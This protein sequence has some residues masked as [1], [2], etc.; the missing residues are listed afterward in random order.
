MLRFIWSFLDY[1]E[2]IYTINRTYLLNYR[3]QSWGFGV[4]GVVGVAGDGGVVCCDGAC[5][6]LNGFGSL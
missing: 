2:K 6:L 4:V 3:V 5:A 1:Y